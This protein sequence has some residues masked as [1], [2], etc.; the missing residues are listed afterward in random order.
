MIIMSNHKVKI[1]DNIN[2]IDLFLQKLDKLLES[3]KNNKIYASLDFEFDMDHKLKKHVLSLGQLIFS[4]VNTDNQ[5][6]HYDTSIYDLRLF[7]NEQK[8]KYINK[9]LLNKSITKI[10]HGSESLDLPAL[11][12]IINNDDNFRIF[13]STIVDTRFLCEAYNLLRK[14]IV[15]NAKQKFKCTIYS[16]LLDTNAI[17]QEQYDK[18]STIKINYNKPWLI[19]NL[20]S[21]QITYSVTD[22]LFLYNLLIEYQNLLSE[23]MI[24]VINETF[25]Y[26]IL[27]RND[28]I[29]SLYKNKKTNFILELLKS[30]NVLNKVIVKSPLRDTKINVNFTYKD[31]ITIDYF[32]KPITRLLYHENKTKI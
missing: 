21:K 13:L 3:N 14:K 26:V 32:R 25:Q 6:T 9:I 7:N 20:S 28:I 30:A 5:V 10:L 11:K 19:N 27:E 4:I 22:V 1:L 29:E 23:K 17:T 18:L 31:L 2:K 8:E 12:Y 15:T 24:E 16:A